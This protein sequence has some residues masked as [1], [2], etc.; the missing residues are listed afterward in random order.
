MPNFSVLTNPQAASAL[1]N[2]NRTNDMVG[3]SQERINTGLRIGSAKDDAATF[4]IALGM[5]SDIAGYKAIRENLALG[6]STMG[7]ASAASDQIAEQIKEIREKVVQA[8]N[9]ETGRDLIQ[10]SIDNAV[11]QIRGFVQSS[12]FNGIN[13]IDGEKAQNNEI[14]SVVGNLVRDSTNTASLQKIDVA[15]QD[16]SIE[17]SSRGLGVLKDVDVVEGKATE[18]TTSRDDPL[19]A[20]INLAAAGVDLTSGEEFT[21]SYK[22]AEGETQTL[23]F[24]TANASSGNFTIRCA[25]GAGGTTSTVAAEDLTAAFT[26]LSADGGPLQGLGFTIASATNGTSVT[27]T[28]DPAFG[29]GEIIGFNFDPL[30]SNT[31]IDDSR[32][33]L[34]E[35]HGGAAAIELTLNGTSRLDLTDGTATKLQEGDTIDVT[36]YRSDTNITQTFTFEVGERGKTVVNGA[37]IAGSANKYSLNYA[38][39]VGTTISAK[40]IDDAAKIIADALVDN[41]AGRIGADIDTFLAGTMGT[42]PATDSI[43]VQHI[44]GQGKIVLVDQIQDTTDNDRVVGFNMANA[45]GG[46]LDFDFMLQQI[47][48]AEQHLK[49]VVG[50]IGSAQSRLED[51]SAFMESLIKAMNDGVGTL[52]DANMAEESARFQALQVQ[53]QLGLQALS[54]ANSNPQAILSLFQ[55]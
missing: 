49:M 32:F 9:N 14:Y 51:Q 7:V 30:G 54:I 4:A 16:L 46:D 42:D 37:S 28:R 39:V 13:L 35:S 26:N 52:V 43:T 29:A 41:T 19:S 21:F 34:N 47:D 12:T 25:T 50:E 20:T 1:L 17:E 11:E 44:V 24:T 36:L 55:G 22:D 53:Q 6:N 27:I 8:S 10:L 3:Q 5:K 31:V 45:P 23:T 40:T 18:T 48:Q 2:L 15:Y 33:T 38:D